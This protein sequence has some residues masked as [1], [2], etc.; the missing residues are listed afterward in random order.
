MDCV[1]VSSAWD[2]SKFCKFFQDFISFLQVCGQVQAEGAVLF[3][4]QLIGL[5]IYNLYLAELAT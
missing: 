3:T 4:A 5:C 1:K 2:I